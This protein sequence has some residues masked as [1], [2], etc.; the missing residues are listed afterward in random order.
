MKKDRNPIT[1]ERGRTERLI[2]KAWQ[3]DQTCYVWL[4]IA[5]GV[6]DHESVMDELFEDFMKAYRRITFPTVE[7][8]EI[9]CVRAERYGCIATEDTIIVGGEIPRDVSLCKPPTYVSNSESRIWHFA[10]GIWLVDRETCFCEY[11]ADK[12][13]GGMII[14]FSGKN[15][16]QL[17]EK[18]PQLRNKIKIAKAGQCDWLVNNW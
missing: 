4:H 5:N 2:H 13:E 1:R 15:I 6:M 12:K 3:F 14:M 9:A 10:G 7:I 11:N 16:F 18:Y 17:L 8:P